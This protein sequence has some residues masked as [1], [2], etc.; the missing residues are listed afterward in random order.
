M[1]CSFVS[2]K[3]FQF[4]KS[5]VFKSDFDVFFQV[6]VNRSVCILAPRETFS[7]HSIIY[8]GIEVISF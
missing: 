6:P 8:S 7:L 3:I 2:D 5:S 1:V 4:I